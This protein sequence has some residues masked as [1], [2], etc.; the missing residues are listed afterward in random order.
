MNY[1]FVA[2]ENALR[3]LQE[4]VDKEYP[5]YASHLTLLQTR[6]QRNIAQE[7]NSPSENKRTLQEDRRHTLAELDTFTRQVKKISFVEFCLKGDSLLSY[8]ATIQKTVIKALGV[9]NNQRTIWPDQCKYIASKLPAMPVL[10]RHIAIHLSN[11]NQIKLSYI[12]GCAA[13]LRELMKN[14]SSIC[15]TGRG[16]K[17]RED[18]Q[19]KLALLEE[20]LKQVDETM[21]EFISM[22]LGQLNKTHRVERKPNISSSQESHSD[23]SNSP[24]D[25][26]I[27][28]LFK[29]N[30][31]K[32][33]S[34]VQRRMSAQDKQ[35]TTSTNLA[36]NGVSPFTHSS[37][38]SEK[39]ESPHSIA[40]SVSV[41]RDA[42]MHAYDLNELEL[43]CGDLNV[44][45]NN[46]GEG[47]LEVKIQRLIDYFRRRDQYEKLVEK[48]LA[49]RP[50]LKQNFFP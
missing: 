25:K 45:I 29:R 20:N 21:D 28:P 49:G 5:G 50:Q 43:L 13:Q 48:V 15:K 24:R 7:Q 42:M 44:S 1:A 36:P 23:V 33:R 16:T 37:V 38:S 47:T 14:F 39:T 26:K 32:R 22:Y 46:L 3:C 4:Q 41:L 30:L 9:F 8:L 6:L 27:P 2:Y 12:N 11:A 31:R 19:R 34:K 10:D 18:I 17:Q 40:P 35:R